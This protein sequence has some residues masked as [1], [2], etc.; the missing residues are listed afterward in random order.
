MKALGAAGEAS[1]LTPAL[2]IETPTDESRLLAFLNRRRFSFA[3]LAEKEKIKQ[4]NENTVKVAKMASGL[5]W[6]AAK[7]AIFFKS[8]SINDRF[9][10]DW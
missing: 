2:A 5:M 8:L 7:M 3:P 6:P 9:L 4:L 1:V 10:T